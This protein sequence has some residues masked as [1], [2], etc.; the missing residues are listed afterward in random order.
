MLPGEKR[1]IKVYE[2]SPKLLAVVGKM[3]PNKQRR[4]VA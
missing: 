3:M 2:V 4:P 1:R